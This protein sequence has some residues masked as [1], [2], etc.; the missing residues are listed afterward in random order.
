MGDTLR[1]RCLG[2]GLGLIAVLVLGACP[3]RIRETSDAGIVTDAGEPDV[4]DGGDEVDGGERDAGGGEDAGSRA[5]EGEDAGEPEPDP[6]A[7]CTEVPCT[8]FTW[9]EPASGACLPG[10]GN[11]SDCNGGT[12]EPDHTCRCPESHHLCDGRCAD[13][14]S[15]LTCGGRCEPC[16]APEGMSATCVEGECG[17]VCAFPSYLTPSG[18]RS[19]LWPGP[20]GDTTCVAVGEGG[21][22]CWGANRVGGLGIGTHGSNAGSPSPVTVNNLT[23]SIVRVEVGYDSHACA[24]SLTGEVWCWGDNLFGGVG[25]DSNTDRYEPV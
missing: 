21:V 18:C 4:E 5:G 8:G 9:C 15:P 25:D 19:G 14:A 13:S 10:C 23:G 7:R 22:R 1:G 16:P 2:I 11:S 20:G 12:C 6:G 24:L 17:A 3:Q